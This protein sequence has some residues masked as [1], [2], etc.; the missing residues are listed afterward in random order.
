MASFAGSIPVASSKTLTRGRKVA[1]RCAHNAEI[2]GANPT[3]ATNPIAVTARMFGQAETRPDQ[4]S[5]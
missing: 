5:R 1:I 3:P 2:V 4:F